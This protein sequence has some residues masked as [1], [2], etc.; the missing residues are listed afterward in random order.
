MIRR[1]SERVRRTAGGMVVS[2]VAGA[3][4]SVACAQPAAPSAVASLGE[5]TGATSTQSANPNFTPADL[6][7]R[8]WTCVTPPTPN[9]IV[10]SHP[11]QGFPV[12]STPPPEDRPA[13]F[14]LWMFDGAGNF[15]GPDPLL[16]SDLYEGQPCDGT[17]QPWIARPAVGYFEC[18]HKVGR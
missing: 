18:V 16:R 17:G 3:A 9:R 12:F 7:A 6:V 13:S 4:L 8:G 10:C 5:T 11:N 15:I 2:L 14:S 1:V